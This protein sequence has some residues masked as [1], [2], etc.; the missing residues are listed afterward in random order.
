[1]KIPNVSTTLLQFEQGVFLKIHFFKIKI[2]C[3]V[4]LLPS[5]YLIFGNICY[6]T[7]QLILIKK[8]KVLYTKN[9]TYAFN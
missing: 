8:R 7:K 1:M 4:R 6:L 5:C 2:D 3:S 9:E